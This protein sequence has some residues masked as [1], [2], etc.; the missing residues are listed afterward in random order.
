MARNVAL[1]LV[2]LLNPKNWV[3]FSWDL[4]PIVESYPFAVHGSSSRANPGYNLLSVD[5]AASIIRVRSKRCTGSRVAQS[6]GC[7][8]CAG[9]GPSIAVVR[10]WAQES[11]GKK[12]SNRLS[13]KQLARKVDGLFKQLQ[14]ERLKINNSRKYLIRAKRRIESYRKLVDV[15]STNDVPGL[16][17]LLSTANKEGWGASKTTDKANL[18]I[19]GRYHPC[20]YTDLD[21][22]LAILAYEYGGDALLHALH[23]SPFAFPTRFTIADLRR[24]T[25]LSITVGPVKMTDILKNIEILFKDIPVGKEGRDEIAGDGHEIAGLCEHA[26]TELDTLKMGSDLTAVHAAAKAVREGRV[27]VGKE[28]SVAAISRHSSSDYGAK[29]VLLMA[30]CKQNSWQE[31]AKILQMINAAWKISPYG[32]ILHGPIPAYASDGDP[33]RKAALYLLCMHREVKPG[34]ALYPHIAGLRGLNLF[35]SEDFAT[36]EFDPKHS[37]KRIRKTFCSKEGLLAN[38]VVVNKNLL[39]QWL[40]RLSGHDWSGQSIHALLNPKDAQHV[41]STVKLL[42]L[43]GDLRFLDASN[44]TPAEA[45]THRALCILGEM[46]D[47]LLD[48]FINPNLSL[49]QEIIQLVKFAHL[50]CAWYLRHGSAFMPPQLYGDLQCLVKS[51]IFK[52]AHSKVLNPSLK[53]FLCLLGDDVLE[54]LFGRSRMI[55]GHAPNMAID[56]LRRRFGSA[57]RIDEI[58]KRRPELEKLAQRLSLGRSRDVDHLSPRNFTGDLAASSCD[59]KA[60]YD[61]GVQ[62]AVEFLK[63]YGYDID[64]EA[65]FSKPDVDLMRPNGGKYPGVSKEVD[66]SLDEDIDLSA[67]GDGS[68][69]SPAE[70]LRFDGAAALAAEKAACAAPPQPHSVWIKLD[71]DDDRKAAHKKTILRTLMDPTLDLEHAKSHDRLLRIR[72]F[73]IGG[74]K[75]DRSLS[76]VHD[77]SAEE[78]LLKLEGLFATLVAVNKTQVSLAILHCTVIKTHATNPPTYLDAAPIAELS[79]PDSHY[80]V[81]GQILSLV[82]FVDQSDILSWAWSTRFIGFESAKTKHANSTSAALQRHLSICING[83]LALPLSTPDLMPARALLDDLAAG[84]LPDAAEA[85]ETTWIFSNSQLDAMKNTLL[86]R[87]EQEDI[88]LQIPVYGPV[89]EGGTFPYEVSLRS[90]TLVSHCLP[91][92]VAPSPKD[93]RRKCLICGKD[94]LGTERQNHMGRHILLSLRGIK[95]NNLI[96]TISSSYPCG[97]CGGTTSNGACSLSIRSGKAISTCLEVYEFQVKA[98]SKSTNA[99]AC[100]NV[101]IQCALCSQTHWKYNMAAH[102]AESHPRWEITTDKQKRQD[103]ETKIALADDEERRL[104]AITQETEKR[105]ATSPPDT[106]RPS[107]AARIADD[108]L[109]DSLDYDTAGVCSGPGIE[110]DVD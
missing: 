10:G 50:S 63:R 87:G 100:T 11:P 83:R 96:A 73:S 94:V 101:P 55:G 62:Q 82:P 64:F 110:M 26:N 33:K 12:P 17:R 19:R 35:T 6:T 24:S 78:H 106:P 53:V 3:D 8:S 47:A 7:P 20:N 58:F 56:E 27:H 67:P 21:K 44:F 57:L 97:F 42:T 48:P 77:K 95:E 46:F 38:G 108:A 30:T 68:A 34:D 54:I 74:E 85:V 102:L 105:Q 90:G 15:I 79:L 13:H 39:A 4:E 9:L 70:I 5:V 45:N 80:E 40:E 41:P 98:A 89:K 107:K 52:I 91:S 76:K 37:W 18:A 71:A 84:V 92:I 29:P 23:K 49:S 22:D 32:E 88:R 104:G 28:F 36:M 65:L 66:R 1:Y 16:P 69:L 31:N 103:F 109:A 72:C 51:A 25:S 59:I 14:N 75:W 99:K 61:E 60:C 43:I 81:S 2:S 93:G 86:A